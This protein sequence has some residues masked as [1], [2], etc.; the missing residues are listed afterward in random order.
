MNRKSPKLQLLDCFSLVLV[1]LVFVMLAAHA[2][3]GFAGGF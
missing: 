1:G 2:C 3:L